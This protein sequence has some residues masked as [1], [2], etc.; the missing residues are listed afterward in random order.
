M[1]LSAFTQIRA[2]TVA[3]DIQTDDIQ[4]N[5]L[6]NTFKLSRKVLKIRILAGFKLFFTH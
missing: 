6:I 5:K 3:L 2:Q 4:K 1:S